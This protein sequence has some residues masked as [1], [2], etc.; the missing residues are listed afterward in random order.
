MPLLVRT[1]D[2]KVFKVAKRTLKMLW[3]DRDLRRV[4]SVQR[5]RIANYIILFHV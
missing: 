1:C 2:V 5:Q 4:M 3:G